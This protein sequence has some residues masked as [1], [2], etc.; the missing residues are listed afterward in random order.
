M[1]GGAQEKLFRGLVVFVNRPAVGAAQL[2]RV[3]ND[4]RQHGFEVQSRAYHLPDF[5][6]GFE[7][8]HRAR[9]FV[10]SGIQFFKQPH[11]L[12]GDDRLVG[13]GF[14]QLDLR[15]GER[16]HLDATCDQSIQ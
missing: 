14:D 3:G 8:A 7:L 13:K 11:V 4:S 15:R 6:E 9:Q 5:A 16:S 1:I 2:H 12:D 10:G